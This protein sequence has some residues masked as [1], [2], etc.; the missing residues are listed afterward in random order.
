MRV[1]YSWLC[2]FVT[3]QSLEADGASSVPSPELIQ[4]LT[5]SFNDLG[6]VVEGVEWVG[7]G[8]EEVVVS[9]VLEIH[10]IEGADKIRRIIVQADED[11]PLQ[12]VCGAFNF[13]VGDKVPLAKLGAVLPGDFAISK[14]KM[15]GIDSFGMLCSAIELGLG[16][17]KSGLMILPKE[18]V[19]GSSISDALGIVRDVVFDLAIE[20]NRPDANCI[21]GVARDLAAWLKIPFTQPK[22]PVPMSKTP[23]E[24]TRLSGV[25]VHCLDHCDRLIVALYDSADSAPTPTYITN[26]LILAGMRPVSP[27]VDISN[28]LMLEL[29][30]PSHPYDANALAGGIISVRLA[31]RG[32][33]LVTLDGVVRTLGLPDARGREST[34]VLIVDGEGNPVGLAG[35]MGGKET[36][37]REDT[38]NLLVELAHFKPMTIARTSKRLG[39]RSEASARFERGVD[40][41]IMDVAL[42]RFSD[43]LGQVPS[44]VVEVV[45]SGA[46]QTWAIDLRVSRVNQI[47]GTELK[48]DEIASH[49]VPIGFGVEKIDAENLRI[50]VPT[51]R[52]DVERE[53][54]VIEEVARQ[55][56]YR[57]IEKLRPYSKTA[58]SLK[59]SQKIRRQIGLLAVGMGFYEAWSATL[60]APGEQER[61][62]DR[63]AFLE[64]ENPLAQ[65]ESVLRRSLLPGLVRALRFNQNRNEEEI[66]LFEAGKV[67]SVVDGEISET[68]R[69]GFL[70][71]HA[72]DS[73]ASA[74]AVFSKIADYFSLAK[75]SVV[76]CYDVESKLDLFGENALSESWQGLHPTRSA[77]LVANGSILGQVGEIDRKVLS[78]SGVENERQV[79]Y[80]ELDFYRLIALIQPRSAMKPISQFPT[81]SVDLAF[82]V[83]NHV[84]A[85]DVEYAL[86]HEVS[87]YV[88]SATLFDVFRGGGVKPRHRSLAFSVRLSAPDRTLS[89]QDIGSV[90]SE[91][92]AVIESRFGAKLRS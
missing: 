37:I 5:D 92:I 59:A 4:R 14:R 40:P 77:Y 51:N 28:Y 18:A 30:Q 75:I 81:A 15:R 35:I 55:Y 41:K 49:I 10:P 62:G 2:D 87:E 61:F 47:L 71:G 72:N 78:A 89:E 79:G 29:G 20:N 82:E 80:L 54:D 8:L 24:S 74:M 43:L 33:S 9:E 70:L 26:R 38:K 16:S 12:I 57:R 65:E 69:V 32:E 25:E 91:C 85:R 7:T 56:G 39:L 83:P 23:G 44:E 31:G 6:L 90:R 68:E 21:I 86:G 27:I 58:G 84:S 48:A 42:A 1:P 36:E 45:A 52:P 88:S 76:N 3:L 60:L 64:V 22:A 73:A 17:D 66:R 19:V 63:G 50:T 11:E 34:D 13:Q 46:T 53:I 67:F